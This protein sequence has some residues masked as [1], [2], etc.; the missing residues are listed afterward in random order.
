M[1]GDYHTTINS[2]D[3]GGAPAS[4]A[5]EAIKDAWTWSR[6]ETPLS[7]VLGWAEGLTSATVGLFGTDL[8][9]IDDNLKPQVAGLDEHVLKPTI[10]NVMK[11]LSDLN[12]N[13]NNNNDKNG[14]Q[15]TN[16]NWCNDS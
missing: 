1:E 16:W 13:N 3:P 2:N 12:N 15:S 4:H 14:V 9:G 10:S 5:Y 11:I 8:K 6:H 7:P